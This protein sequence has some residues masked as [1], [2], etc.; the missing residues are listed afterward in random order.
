M[1]EDFFEGYL[2]LYPIFASSLGD[3]RYNRSLTLDLLP[4]HRA[5]RAELIAEARHGLEAVHRQDLPHERRWHLDAFVHVLHQMAERLTFDDHLIPV[6]PGVSLQARFPHMAS[7]KG[8]HPFETVADYD[9]F[10]SRIEDFDRWVDAVVANLREGMAS[11]VVEPRSMIDAVLPE[12]TAQ[13]RVKV[14][15]SPFYR[16][17][18]EMP[19]AFPAAERKRL[20]AAYESAIRDRLIPAYERLHDFLRREYRQHARDT[21]S[22]SALPWGERAYRHLVRSFTTTD[23]EPEEIF[24]LG[25]VE[26]E[27]IE[28][29]MRKL[30][31]RSRIPGS[32]ASFRQ[33]MASDPRNYLD[34]PAQVMAGFEALRMKVTASLD[35]LFGLKPAATFD[36]RRV[37]A[38]RAAT[39]PGA[40]YEGP[41]A[42]GSKPG[43]FYFNLRGRYYPK[44]TM[45]AL[46]LHE[47]LPGH[48]FQIA[49]ARE[50]EGLPRFL[51][52]GYFGA[53][54]E[55]WG[56]YCEGLGR[57]LGLYTDASQYYGRLV[58]DL[59]RAGRLL[60]DVGIHFKGWTRKQATKYLGERNLGWALGEIDRY[61]ARPGQA[62][63]YKVGEQ[64]IWRLRRRAEAVLGKSFDVRRFHDA[65]LRDGP[66]PLAVL[67]AKIDHW[68]A[69]ERAASSR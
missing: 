58:Y 17:I 8:H 9:D 61:T 46:F 7:G 20:T 6:V 33:R 65:I 34:G 47:A 39:A 68:I 55:G 31:R 37:E 49:L 27:R 53:Y 32:L 45:E 62:L 16:A 4:E 50:R 29:E 48:H 43:A 36:I 44:T 15:E 41:S 38:Y 19:E 28:G 11:G 40:F 23:L 52:Y 24:E 54:T 3:R 64:E 21:L 12:L 22:L 14:R 67:S 18:D 5:R 35:R 59:G 69:D 1:F 56:L 13:F 25:L 42:D 2:E 60:G 66:L 57:E 26:V 51:R 63:S 30:Q 10:L